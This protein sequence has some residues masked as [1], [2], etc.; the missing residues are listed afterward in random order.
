MLACIKRGLT[1][2]LYCSSLLS[3]YLLIGADIWSAIE[4]L[5]SPAWLAPAL[6]D[7]PTLPITAA[8]VLPMGAKT[9][10]GPISRPANVLD[11]LMGAPLLP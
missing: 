4:L 2:P 9:P 8:E 3:I 5:E 10:L 1:P 6:E 7:C 11:W